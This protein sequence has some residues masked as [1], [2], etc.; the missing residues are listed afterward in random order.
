MSGSS[1]SDVVD[2]DVDVEV[3]LEE[4]GEEDVEVDVEL[5]EAVVD[6]V[7]D[8]AFA[9]VVDVSSCSHWSPA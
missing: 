7:G 9:D 5:D 3:E 1:N 4:E 8:V 2:V 6:E